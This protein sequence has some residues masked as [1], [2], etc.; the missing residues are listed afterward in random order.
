[1]KV[2]AIG[3]H[4]DDIEI[5]CGGT[6]SLHKNAGHEIHLVIATRGE[7]GGMTQ[8]MAKIR[9]QEALEAAIV[10]SVVGEGFPLIYN[11]QEAGNPRR[12]AFFEKDPI[13][14]RQ[15]PIGDLYKKLF[16]FV[17]YTNVKELLVILSTFN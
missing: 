4:P 10:L 17:K 5:G 6:L 9:S 14:W 8:D 3:T 12:L 1:M 11:G 2:L 16:S 13:D 15:H 7:R